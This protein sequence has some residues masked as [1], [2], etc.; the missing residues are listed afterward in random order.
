MRNDV[1]ILLIIML[2]AVQSTAQS[3]GIGIM[4]GKRTAIIPFEKYSNLIVVPIWLNQGEVLN[5]I[6]DTG[7]RYTIL[8]RQ[9]YIPNTKITMDKQVK[10]LGSDMSIEMIAYLVPRMS[11]RISNVHFKNQVLLVLK[12]DY[13]HLENLIGVPIHGIIG[14]DL[15]KRFIVKI[16]YRN[17]ILTLYEREAFKIPS[18]FKSLDLFMDE[19]KPYLYSPIRIDKDTVKPK[20][21]ID[22]GASVSLLLHPDVSDEIQL[23]DDV[24]SGSLAH[25]LGGEVEGLMGRVEQLQLPPFEFRNLVTHFQ[26]LTNAMD[27]IYRDDREGIIGGELMSRFTVILDYHRQ[28]LYLKPNRK[29]NRTFNYDKSGVSFLAS[30]RDLKNYIA[31]RVLPDSPAA[32][33]GLEVG[34]ILLRINGLGH[35][36]ITLQQITRILQGK[37]QKRIRLVLRRNEEKIKVEFRLKDLI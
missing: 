13:L 12:E 27:S 36:S 1:S 6:V 7:A 29:Y 35:R 32:E 20:L 8:T 33:A 24:I 22:T 21:L 25:G 18:G 37:N 3:Y 9:K 26:D 34:D 14:S 17:N 2:I 28:K 15:F 16:D 19:H 30:G 23:P 5:F 11:L 31:R 4:G 10:L